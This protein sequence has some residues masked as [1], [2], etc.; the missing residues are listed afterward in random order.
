VNCAMCHHPGGNAIVSFFLRRDLPFDKLNTN[1]G[2]GIGTFGIREAKIIAPGD[3]YRSLLLYR[4]SKLGYARMPYIGSQ[5]VDS[6]GV[7]LVA[8]WIQSLPAEGPLAVS[9]PLA[10]ESPEAAALSRLASTSLS[11][12]ERDEAIGTL[13]KSTESSLALVGQLHR[14][15]LPEETAKAAAA[16]GSALNTSDIRGLFETFIPESLRR[17]TLGTQINPQ[18]ILSRRGDQQRGKLIFFSDGARCR[19]CH[20]IDEPRE[21]LGPSLQ[22]INKKYTR[23]PE[24]LEHVL[25]P[26]QK[27]EDPYAAYSVLTSDGRALSGLLA[28]QG[29]KEIVIRSADKKTT[30]IARNQVAEMRKS[31]KSL[32]PDNILSDLTAQ[33][34]A[35]LLAYIQS[36]GPPK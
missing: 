26:S 33:E 17:P 1:K 24:M 35:D 6:A 15:T 20:E 14:R 27:I 16:L 34:A 4:M 8:A 36:L 18:T 32:M 23:L 2:T 7:A 25:Q 28:E 22:E 31:Q 3:P 10:K 9:P 30:R 5:V 11:R 19:A 29:E 13:L 21:S 12:D